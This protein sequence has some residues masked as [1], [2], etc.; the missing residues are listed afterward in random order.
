MSHFSPL[1]G[2][3]C[4]HSCSGGGGCSPLYKFH[5]GKSFG[6]QSMVHAHCY[7]DKSVSADQRRY[8]C[9]EDDGEHFNTFFGK[10]QRLLNIGMIQ[11]SN[12]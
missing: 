6:V 8:A 12:N 5:V 7:K 10:I 3:H 11:Y 4:S 1:C 2:I 9:S